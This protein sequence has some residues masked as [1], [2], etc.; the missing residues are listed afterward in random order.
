M[1][2]GS[3][4]LD[5]TGSCE[6]ELSTKL[7]TFPAEFPL[8]AGPGTEVELGTDLKGTLAPAAP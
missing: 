5:D 8:Y 2:V 7:S 6:I 4:T 3:I 1:R